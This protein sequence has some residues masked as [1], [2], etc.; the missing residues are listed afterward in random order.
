MCLCFLSLRKNWLCFSEITFMF[1]LPYPRAK[2]SFLFPHSNF[3]DELLALM[4]VLFCKFRNWVRILGRLNLFEQRGTVL[5]NSRES[6]RWK[7]SARATC[8]KFR[9]W[10][11][12]WVVNCKLPPHSQRRATCNDAT[13]AGRNI[14]IRLRIQF[15]AAG[16]ISPDA[17]SG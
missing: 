4:P 14:S 12:S 16:C 8:T 11:F 10:K 2:E 6:V 15:R 13:R 7:R 3:A 9:H 17:Q 5:M 1:P